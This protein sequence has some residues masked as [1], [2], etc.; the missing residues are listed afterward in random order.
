[1]SLSRWWLALAGPLLAACDDGLL[2][3]FEPS[4]SATSGAGPNAPT[5]PLVIDDFEDGDPRANEP[6]GWWYPIND[7]GGTQ[8]FGIEPVSGRGGSVYALRTHSSGF[9]DWAAVGVNLV[10]DA[11]PL[12]ASSYA[13]LCL[14][15]RVEPGSSSAIEVHLLRG[16]RHYLEQLSLT[17]AWARRCVSL[18]GFIGP[19]EAALE[20][21]DLIALQF[22]FTPGAPF[23]FWLD[24]VQLVPP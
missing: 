14:V 23:A 1:M 15:A 22:F 6:L 2:H 4:A 21:T 7:G 19:Q 5:S 16:G 9:E 18:R 17:E 11:A 13:E 24:D 3:A 8:G 12:D 20:P 10:G